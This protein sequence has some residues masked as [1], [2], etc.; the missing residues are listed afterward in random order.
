MDNCT[1]EIQ[2]VTPVGVTMQ[3]I[4]GRTSGRIGQWEFSVTEN[5]SVWMTMTATYTADNAWAIKPNWPAGDHMVASDAIDMIVLLA[6]A[7][8]IDAILWQNLE[9]IVL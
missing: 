5:P 8:K 7:E 2:A 4:V 3:A 9:E 1:E 6:L